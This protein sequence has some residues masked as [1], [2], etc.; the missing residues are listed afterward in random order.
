MPDGYC[1]NFANCKDMKAVKFQNMKRHDCHMFLQMLMPIAF[2][3]LPDDVLE[4]FV[5]SSEFFKNLCLTVLRV[6]K[7][8]EMQHN[9]SI[10]LCKLERIFPLGFFSVM[11]HLP[12]H[13]AEEA[14]LGGLVQYRWIYPFER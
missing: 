14:Y 8:Q 1:S 4:P 2:R 12:I 10:I 6:D 7:L 9:I 5:E 11:E 3:A 13:L